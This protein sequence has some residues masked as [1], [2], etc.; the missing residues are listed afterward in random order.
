MNNGLSTIYYRVDEQHLKYFEH[1]G[2]HSLFIGQEGI[3]NLETFT[4][5]GGDKKP[6]RNAL[7]KMKTLGYK[8]IFNYP[9]Q[10]DGLIQK[11]KQ[12]SDDWLSDYDKKE[13]AFTLGVWNASELKNQIIFTI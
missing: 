8:C 12:V 13:S 11:L 4:L 2:K 9:M 3:V 10:K 7:N 5:E 6:E 1:F